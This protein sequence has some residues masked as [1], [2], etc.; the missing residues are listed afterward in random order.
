[1]QG[2]TV[3]LKVQTISLLPWL[4][5]RR[6]GVCSMVGS[7]LSSDVFR[8]GAGVV[9]DGDLG[10]SELSCVCTWASFAM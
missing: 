3:G 1:M 2:L 8:R 4:P 9:A 10:A 7:L 6:D 5:G